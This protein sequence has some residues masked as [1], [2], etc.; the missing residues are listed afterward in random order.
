MA[1]SWKTVRAAKTM[2]KGSVITDLEEGKTDKE[3]WDNFNSRIDKDIVVVSDY[4]AEFCEILL[5]SKTP[6]RLSLV[7]DFLPKKESSRKKELNLFAIAMC[8]SHND[9]ENAV[10]YIAK[11]RES[12]GEDKDILVEE[13]SYYNTFEPE[14]TEKIASLL[15]AIEA[16]KGV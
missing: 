14:N 3:V 4:M 5:E 15:T 16:Y 2:R 6:F 12:Y 9:S 1:V 13:L 7:T 10:T 8:V 11:Y